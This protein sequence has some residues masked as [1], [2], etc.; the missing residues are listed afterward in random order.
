M[1]PTAGS[2]SD[3][4]AGPGRLE[5]FVRAL[6]R[7]FTANLKSF[8]RT[9]RLFRITLRITI[10]GRKSWPDIREQLYL[11][12]NRSILF[13]AVTMGVLG[14]ITIY[15]TATQIERILPDFTMMGGTF[16]KVM[17]K[18]MGPTIAALMIATRVGTG[19]A[20]EI[21]SMVVTEQVDALKMSNTDPI[22][23]LVVP[24]FIA[25]TVMVLVLTIFGILVASICAML[26]AQ[27]GFGVNPRT[28][29]R[30]DMTESDDVIMCIWRCLTYGAVIPVI[31]A[32]AGLEA[33]GGSEGVGWATTRAVVNS[34][35]AVIVLDFLLSTAG[36]LIFKQ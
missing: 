16:I 25:C 12:G 35:F 13:I 2:P 21:G 33:R 3:R 27:A 10:R 20:A 32:Q 9:L 4:A 5:R 1:S 14:V 29:W 7:P 11:V 26:T 17:I 30:V 36:Y 34:S 28:F 8:G 23:Y 31:S 19:I 24:R 22:E 15:Q 18:Q 6:G